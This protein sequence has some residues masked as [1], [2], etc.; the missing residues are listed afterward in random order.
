MEGR[1]NPVKKLGRILLF[2]LIFSVFCVVS[3]FCAEDAQSFSVNILVN[4][5][6]YAE[7]QIGA[8]VDEN[9]YTFQV[10]ELLDALGLELTYNEETRVAAISAVPDTLGAVLFSELEV[11][12]ASGEPSEEPSGEPSAE[13]GGEAS[14]EP[15]EEPAA[16]ASG[17]PSPEPAAQPDGGVS[18]ESAAEASGEPAEIA[19]APESYA[20]LAFVRHWK[21]VLAA[22]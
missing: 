5:D 12:S 4:G 17:E 13:P 14:G 1:Y 7:V 11:G 19:E 21:R 8:S 16:E 20:G 2:A 15:S 18:E 3:A 22:K 10:N 6:E 9:V